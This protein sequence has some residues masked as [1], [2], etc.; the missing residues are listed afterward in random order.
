MSDQVTSDT[1]RHLPHSPKDEG[2]SQPASG[3]VGDFDDIFVFNAKSEEP[4][5][6]KKRGWFRNAGVEIDLNQIA[7]P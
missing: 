5:P 7:D 4:F 3:Y 1:Y 2:T 6:P